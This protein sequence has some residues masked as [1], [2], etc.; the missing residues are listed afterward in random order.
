MR[1]VKLLDSISFVALQ[2]TGVF[3]PIISIRDSQII[4]LI[5]IS[6]SSILY[7]RLLMTCLVLALNLIFFT[8]RLIS[9]DFRYGQPILS[10]LNNCGWH[11][12]LS[13]NRSLTAKLFALHN[14]I[15]V[16]IQELLV[17]TQKL[18]PCTCIN[19]LQSIEFYQVIILLLLMIL[20]LVV[21]LARLQCSNT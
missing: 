11:L 1:S 20:A 16:K 4:I 12:L 2:S 8:I 18:K 3:G 14:P 9:N 17:S 5:S 19:K 13:S 10:F 7:I 15:E 6:R 21:M